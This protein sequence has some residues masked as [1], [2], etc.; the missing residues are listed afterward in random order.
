MKALLLIV[1]SLFFLSG[2]SAALKP[3]DQAPDF[4]LSDADGKEHALNDYRGSIVALYFYPKNDTPGCTKQGCS[5]RDGFS[6]LKEKNVVVL[7]IS[8]DDIASHK[9]FREKYNLPFTL[10]SDADK[11]VAK[12][13]GVAG[14]VFAKRVTYIIDHDGKILHIIEKVDTSDHAQQILDLLNEAPR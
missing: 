4:K 13:Y 3:G 1:A 5:L 14:L 6:D 11:T 2:A 9:K 8:Y 10:L 12:A 7:G